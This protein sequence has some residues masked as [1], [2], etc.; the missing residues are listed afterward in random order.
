MV[1]RRDQNPNDPK[2]WDK[3]IITIYIKPKS[4]LMVVRCFEIGEKITLG[5]RI[6]SFRVDIRLTCAV[7]TSDVTWFFSP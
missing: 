3:N 4:I 2:C 6:K 5:P 1:L 7:M